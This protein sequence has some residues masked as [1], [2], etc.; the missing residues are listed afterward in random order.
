VRLAHERGYERE[1][2]QRDQPRRV[3]D[4]A[5]REAGD[6]DDVLRLA[7]DLAHERRAAR[8]LAARAVEP[9]LQLAVLEV[10]EVERRRVLHQADAGRVREALGQEA[11]DE[12]D[13]AAHHVRQHGEGQLQREQGQQVV[14]EPAREPAAE[15]PARVAGAG[16]ADDLV[17][18]QLADE[19]RRDGQE[20][21]DETAGDRGRGQAR[22][23]LPDGLE[24]RRK[25]AQ[26]SEAFAQGPRRGGRLAVTDG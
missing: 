22:A 21:A 14:D 13:D 1:D 7:E 16:Q 24:E 15:R 12:R 17:D 25:V 3:R 8:R 11:V 26:R 10:L 4:Q 9:V 5:D 18:D 23:R 19:E 2:E 6:G 20:R